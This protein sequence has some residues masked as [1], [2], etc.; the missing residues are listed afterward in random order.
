[1]YRVIYPVSNFA[2]LLGMTGGMCTQEGS[3]EMALV[4]EFVERLR[5]MNVSRQTMLG[6][7]LEVMVRSGLTC[8]EVSESRAVAAVR[9]RYW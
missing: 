5:A 8:A 2:C 3:P 9:S 4:V 1:M 6:M 7:W